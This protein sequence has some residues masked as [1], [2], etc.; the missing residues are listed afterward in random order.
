MS[1][2]FNGRIEFQ[3]Q[4]VTV[5]NGGTT[6]GNINLNGF[7]MVGVIFPSALTSTSMTFQ[8]SQDGTTFTALYNTDGNALTATV[9][10]S[11]ILLFTPGDFVGINYVRLVLGSAEGAERSL[12]VISRTFQ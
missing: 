5:A 11:R 2:F 4:T 12:Q 7:G 1:E 10:A 3:T 6:T 9:A 8:G